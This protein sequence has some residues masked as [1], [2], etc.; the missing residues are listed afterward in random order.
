[1]MENAIDQNEERVRRCIT[2]QDVSKGKVK[3]SLYSTKHH[4]MKTYWGEEV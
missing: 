1:M 2:S 3:L 4:V